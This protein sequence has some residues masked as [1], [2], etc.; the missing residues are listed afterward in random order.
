MGRA[1]YGKGK[2][3]VI[4]EEDACVGLVNGREGGG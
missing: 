3:G 2:L 1:W 4:P